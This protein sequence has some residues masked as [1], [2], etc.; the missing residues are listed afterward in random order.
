MPASGTQPTDREL[1]MARMLIE[2]LAAPFEAER[3]T[4]EHR[5]RVLKTIEE[6]TPKE[7]P[8]APPSPTR[9]MDLMAALEASVKAA[10]AAKTEAAAAT[11]KP[12]RRR[13]RGA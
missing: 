12:V 1:K 3:F 13:A 8:A 5:A 10:K 11:P 7:A 4:D 2:T 9:V 6:R